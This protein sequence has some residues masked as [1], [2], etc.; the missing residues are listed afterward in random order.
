MKKTLPVLLSVMI[1]LI[2]GCGKTREELSEFTDELKENISS[3]SSQQT[4]TGS[5]T[6]ELTNNKDDVILA[7]RS[8]PRLKMKT[9]LKEFSFD[10]DGDGV[11]EKIELHTQA[12]K[13][14]DGE[15]MWDDGQN[16]L[17]VIVD[18]NEFYSLFQDRIQLGSLYF[19]VWQK[20]KTPVISSAIITGANAGL[21]NYIYDGTQKGYRIQDGFDTGSINLLYNSIPG[22]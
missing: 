6:N 11:D 10:F 12:E 22:Y 2:A 18:G 19:G 20:D 8:D 14:Q 3:L 9:K 13:S 16:W 21:K 4:Q 5:L 1:L 7:T 17:L 15:M